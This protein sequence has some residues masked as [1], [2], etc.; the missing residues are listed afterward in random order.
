[1]KTYTILP[2]VLLT[3]LVI[4]CATNSNAHKNQKPVVDKAKIVEN[5]AGKNKKV[6]DEHGKFVDLT[7][8]DPEFFRAKSK[9]RL[10]AF[11]VIISSDS[12]KLRQIRFTDHFKRTPD[13]GGDDL[14]K[15]EIKQY[16][17]TNYKDDGTVDIKLSPYTGKLENVKFYTRVPRINQ[18]ANIIQ[19]DATRWILEHARKDDP[20]IL[21]YRINYQVILQKKASRKEVIKVIKKR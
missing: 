12:Y 10:E 9:D 7:T 8:D 6:M 18:I 2:L 15:E 21:H 14:M 3:S 16:D 11:R 1:M 4:Q 5:P 20:S 17:L 13:K 19:N